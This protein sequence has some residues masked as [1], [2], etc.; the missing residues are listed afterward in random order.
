MAEIVK[1]QFHPNVA[2]Q[3]GSASAGKAKECSARAI[4][5]AAAGGAL[6]VV[7]GDEQS[8]HSHPPNREEGQ[9]VKVVSNLKR[10][11]QEHPGIPPAQI[12]RNELTAVPSGAL[13]HTC[14]TL[15]GENFLLIDSHE[16]TN[17][18]SSSDSDGEN[19]QNR[20]RVII[21]GKRRNLMELLGRSIIWFLDGTFKV[22]PGL[23]VQVFTISG[24]VK[25]TKSSGEEEVLAVPLIY[26]FLPSKKEEHYGQVLKEVIAAA[27]E[28][29]VPF[30]E[31][32]RAMSDFELAILNS[33]KEALA[34]TE[35]Q[36]CFFHL[37]ESMYRKGTSPK[38]GHLTVVMM[39][40]NDN[41]KITLSYCEVQ[42][43][44]LQVAYDNR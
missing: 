3:T 11:S 7:K 17:S 31:P 13:H 40:E 18:G 35:L 44:G 30:T 26:A 36:C 15:I 43:V 29:Q 5:L 42:Q 2:E 4:T 33:I 6:T 10:L 12:L 34:V 38:L 37:G 23:F 24:L 21:F 27:R 9:A 39:Q 20:H 8:P 14:K 41:L 28:Q 1:S 19:E 25:R 32:V 16:D 22:C